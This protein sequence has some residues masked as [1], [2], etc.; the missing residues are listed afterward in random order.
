MREE[1]LE[2]IERQLLDIK[3]KEIEI[4][5]MQRLGED[6]KR[7]GYDNTFELEKAEEALDHLKS[8]YN[9]MTIKLVT[10]NFKTI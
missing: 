10:I 5:T 1:L 4:K 7:L 9:E 8:R 2:E 3:L 6:F